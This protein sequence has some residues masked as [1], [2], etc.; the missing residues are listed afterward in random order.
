[1]V[2]RARTA[3]QSGAISRTEKPVLINA[4]NIVYDAWGNR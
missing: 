3:C 1:M 4:N 2:N